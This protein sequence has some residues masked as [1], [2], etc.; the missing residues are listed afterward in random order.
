[1]CPPSSGWSCDAMFRCSSLLKSQD[2]RCA[3]PPCKLLL[4]YWMLNQCLKE[5]KGP[6]PC[7][8]HRT[9]KSTSFLGCSP[10]EP[11]NSGFALVQLL[12]AGCWAHLP[13]LGF[14]FVT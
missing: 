2:P 8:N 14:S 11:G 12:Q 1:M 13:A 3:K 10:S 6:D 9:L 7:H 5:E 4:W